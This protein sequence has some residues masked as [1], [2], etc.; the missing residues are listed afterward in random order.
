MTTQIS[1]PAV[2]AGVV[3]PET[4]LR[5]PEW[6]ALTDRGR[7]RENN[8]D[9]W[10][11]F[12][13]GASAGPL[14]G[15]LAAWPAKGMLFVLS[16]GMGGARAGEEASRFCVERLAG[17]LLARVA[18]TDAN[19]AMREAILATHEALT[20]LGRTNPDWR[21]MGA[22][23][24][25]LWLLPAGDFVLGHIGDSRIYRHEAGEW[26]R[27]TEDHTLGDGLVRRGQITAE[28]VVRFKFRSLLEQVMGGDGRP[29][30][31]Q[32]IR[33]DCRPDDAFAL[34]SDGFYRPLERGLGA[35]LTAAVQA[36][37]LATGVGGLIDAANAAGGPDNI[38]I[39]LVRPAGRGEK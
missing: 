36:P 9:S 23:L 31:P 12:A 7:H 10:G 37:G 32:I 5:P 16:D 38:T 28:A 1:K 6:A 24:S 11:A 22:T 20:T 30:D 26:I 29:L 39:V 8:E 3:A 35:R 2:A 25:A 4:R 34:C 15:G 21:G 13:L 27:M 18:M 17:E 33:G 14:T 19:A